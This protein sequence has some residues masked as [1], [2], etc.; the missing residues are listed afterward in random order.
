MQKFWE[1]MDEYNNNFYVEKKSDEFNSVKELLRFD[2][3]FLIF[4]V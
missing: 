1:K 3:L 4:K 2:N